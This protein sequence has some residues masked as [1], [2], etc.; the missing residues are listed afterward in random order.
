MKCIQELFV[1]TLQLYVSIIISKIKELK[2]KEESP[3]RGRTAWA[4]ILATPPSSWWDIGS[5]TV[6]CLSFFPCKMGMI[7]VFY[8]LELNI[9]PYS[10]TNTVSSISLAMLLLLFL[11]H[12]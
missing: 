4:R 5:V 7:T 11:A 8:L 6:P 1:L 12:K 3:P 10:Y 9:I 2:T